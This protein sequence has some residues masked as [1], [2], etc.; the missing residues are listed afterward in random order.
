MLAH[1]CPVE[2]ADNGMW[3]ISEAKEESGDNGK[4][5]PQPCLCVVDM[6]CHQQP[7]VPSL[8]SRWFSPPA[9]Q[10]LECGHLAQVVLRGASR[11]FKTIPA[12]SQED[13][14]HCFLE[15]WTWWYGSILRPEGYMITAQKAEQSRKT[16]TRALSFLTKPGISLVLT[17]HC[18]R[19]HFPKNVWLLVSSSIM[20][21]QEHPI[22]TLNNLMFHFLVVLIKVV[23]GQIAAKK[24]LFFQE[25]ESWRRGYQNCAKSTRFYPAVRVNSSE[26]LPS[27][28]S[29]SLLSSLDNSNTKLLLSA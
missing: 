21:S 20:H 24:C 27:W 12:I 19:Q 7:P 5:F 10:H 2:Q 17:F 6:T 28:V 26:I 22:T 29:A 4:L 25:E 1:W 9:A 15:H 18:M 11:S 23:M 8:T 13:I 14:Q 3:N 16:H